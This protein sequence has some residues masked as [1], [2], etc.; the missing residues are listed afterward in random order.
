MNIF[1]TFIDCS[2]SCIL[3]RTFTANTTITTNSIACLSL[4]LEGRGSAF[5]GT[6]ICLWRDRDLPLE[7]RGICLWREGVYFWREGD[8]HGWG[9]D[10]EGSAME[11]PDPTLSSEICRDTLN[12][13]SVR[14]LLECI[15]VNRTLTSATTFIVIN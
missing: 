14:I 6:G 3:F 9:L 12:R 11:G 10:G 5:G 2:E 4:P 7:G 13:R 8:L 1:T 15:L